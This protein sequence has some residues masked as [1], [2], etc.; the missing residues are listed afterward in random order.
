MPVAAATGQDN[1]TPTDPHPDAL[2][3]EAPPVAVHA[4]HVRTYTRPRLRAE[5]RGLQHKVHKLAGS[6]AGGGATAGGAASP[7]LEAIASCES[8]GDAASVGGGGAFRRKYQFTYGT[9]AS[10]GGPG[11]PAAAPEAEQDKRARC[12]CRSGARRRGRSAPSDRVD[13]RRWMPPDFAPPSPSAPR[14]RI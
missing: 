1:D 9:W 5:N 7:Q 10:V 8:S 4:D 14:A 13:S 2:Y 6:N 3:T 12:C 11:D